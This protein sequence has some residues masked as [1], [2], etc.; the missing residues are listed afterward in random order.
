MAATSLRVRSSPWA[1][2]S[3]VEPDARDLAVEAPLG[4]HA[5]RHRMHRL[6]AGLIGGDAAE[7]QVV[8]E[9]RRRADARLVV[10]L[11]RRLQAHRQHPGEIG[12]GD[13]EP[14]PACPSRRPRRCRLSL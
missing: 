4:Q 1:I 10:E 13:E 11:D 2:D 6:G 7:E 14:V 3:A 12:A 8:L 5:A 9:A